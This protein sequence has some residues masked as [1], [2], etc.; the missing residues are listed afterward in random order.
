MILRKAALLLAAGGLFLLPFLVYP[1]GHSMPMQFEAPKVM[2]AFLLGNFALAL[3]LAEYFSPVLAALHAA[4]SISVMITGFGAM[5]IYP[6][7]H[8]V[9]AIALGAWYTTRLKNERKLIRYM[10]YASAGIVALHAYVQVVGLEPWVGHQITAHGPEWSHHFV[11]GYAPGVTAGIPIAFLRQR[12]LFGAFMAPV[13]AACVADLGFLWASPLILIAILTKSSFT[14]AALGAGIFIA[15]RGQI[16]RK[17]MRAIFL[18]ALVLLVIIYEANPK[19]A[20]F[21]DDGRTRIWSETYHAWHDNGRH[22]QLWG[23]G[24][25]AFTAG[26]A[27]TFESKALKDGVGDF[28]QA[29]NDYL[30]VL[31][32]FGLFGFSVMAA[33]LIYLGFC[34]YRLWWVGGWFCSRELIAA[35]AGLGAFLVNACG[36]FPFQLSPHYMLAAIFLCIVLRHPR[37]VQ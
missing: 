12:T 21:S 5:Q 2:G 36:N 24:P 33:A 18:G 6:Y 10:I 16:N 13:A 29:H 30:Q 8:W 32:D 3:I 34:Y 11:M 15:L 31:F 14:W 4:F 25:G 26:F 27:S 23:F 37:E 7:A 35:F 9:A 20:R 28:L 17:L 22:Y 19:A 1:W